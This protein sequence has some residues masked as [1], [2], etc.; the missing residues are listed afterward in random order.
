VI[1]ALAFA[2][3]LVV[4]GGCSSVQLGYR[5]ADTIL[6]WQADSY[7]DLEG[8]QSEELDA[9]IAAFLAW[10]RARALPQYA[11]LLDEAAV[12]AS[13]GIAR[14]DALWAYDSARAQLLEAL[15]TAA[16]GAGP[17][18]DRLP[19][20]NID[21]LERRL[22]EN[23]RK[24]A[25]ENLAGTPEDRRKRRLRRNIERLEE[26]L[27]SLSEAQGERVRQYTEAAPL[28]GDL[29]DR[30]RKRRQSELLAM[31]RARQASLRLADWMGRWESD[32][33]PAFAAAALAQRTAFIDM[34]VDIDRSLS[35]AQR[36]HLAER[37]RGYADDARALARPAQGKAAN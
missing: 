20:E 15:R 12:R 36:Q 10:H 34:L 19:A 25:R 26:W 21:H 31:L 14:E 22:A 4:L 17:L 32:R 9:R 3:A 33:A 30:D 11:R 13:R 37:L 35:S 24:F 1:R 29:R 18:L 2:L 16:A 7:L 23:N 5:N 6:R 8:P 28:A 27:G